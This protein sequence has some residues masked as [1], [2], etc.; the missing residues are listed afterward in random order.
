MK[1]RTVRD[2]FKPQ[3]RVNNGKP[4]N[5]ESEK[6]EKGEIKQRKSVLTKNR[7]HGERGT[8]TRDTRNM[9]KPLG[10][11]LNGIFS[12]SIFDTRT[13]QMPTAAEGDAS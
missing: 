2:H 9:S 4:Q 7:Q 12:K 5:T 8:L 6:Q 3:S 13:K 11:K 10:T 1:L